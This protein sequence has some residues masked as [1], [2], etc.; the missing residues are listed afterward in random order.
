MLAKMMIPVKNNTDVELM[1]SDVQTRLYQLQDRLRD[2]KTPVF[3]VGDA[4]FANANRCT[5]TVERP[6][7]WFIRHMMV[8]QTKQELYF[9][10]ASRFER[11]GV[12][13]R[14]RLPAQTKSV[15]LRRF[16]GVWQAHVRY[17]PIK[18]VRKNTWLGAD[19]GKR[20]FL[21]LSNGVGIC[22]PQSIKALQESLK[23][24]KIE[25]R[26][27][28]AM[29]RELNRLFRLFF[30]DTIR[31][32]LNAAEYICI[33]ALR[34]DLA[35]VRESRWFS[36]V[37]MLK[38]EARKHGRKIIKINPYMTTQKCNNCGHE[39]IVSWGEYTI[40]CTACGVSVDRDLNAAKNIR[41]KG[42]LCV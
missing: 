29:K 2:A 12:E 28:K 39:N 3:A 36:F 26:V 31:R 20:T 23:S 34:R 16:N 18:K 30:K 4:P 9:K 32:M 37:R 11:Y 42:K 10:S 17:N 6:Y 15:T 25:R 27:R 8:A 14:Q 38:Q 7:H 13:L 35:G 21:T 5:F 19:F 41:D 1:L 24:R 40:H 22:I 33:E